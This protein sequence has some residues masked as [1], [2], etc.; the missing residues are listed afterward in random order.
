MIE[1]IEMPN[2]LKM[3]YPVQ[4]NV[5]FVVKNDKY[6]ICWDIW[7][8]PDEA[9]LNETLGLKNMSVVMAAT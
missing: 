2:V 5:I 6:S 9:K 4:I 3:D 1:I 7:E 8:N